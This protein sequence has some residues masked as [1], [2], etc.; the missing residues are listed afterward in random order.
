MENPSEFNDRLARRLYIEA[1]NAGLSH[2]ALSQRAG[3]PANFVNSFINDQTSG[4]S[5]RG[6]SAYALSSLARALGKSVDDILAD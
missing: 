1:S 6:I 5:R 2:R 3:L 4:K